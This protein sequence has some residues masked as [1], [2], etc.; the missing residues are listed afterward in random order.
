MRQLE[1]KVDKTA[2]DVN[3]IRGVLEGYGR[4]PEK[5]PVS[6]RPVS[7]WQEDGDNASP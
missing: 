5:R 4:D 2:A 7:E 3:W 6:R 1:M